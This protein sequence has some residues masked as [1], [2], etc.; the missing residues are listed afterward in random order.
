MRLALNSAEYCRMAKLLV[1]RAEGP[2]GKVMPPMFTQKLPEG[3]DLY[4]DTGG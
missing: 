4:P 2:G 3:G 1:G